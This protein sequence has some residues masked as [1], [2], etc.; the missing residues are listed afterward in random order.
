M[1]LPTD[2]KPIAPRS[3]WQCVALDL[4]FQPCRGRERTRLSHRRSPSGISNID[5]EHLA[6]APPTECQLRQI[7]SAGIR[8]SAVSRWWNYSW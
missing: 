7:V 2:R 3:Q 8:Y 1:R 4:R 5:E 6:C